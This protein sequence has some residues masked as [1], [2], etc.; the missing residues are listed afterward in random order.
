VQVSHVQDHVTHAVIGANAAQ[1]FSIAATAEFFN[2]LSNTLYSNK[3][4]AVV[5]E[6]LCNA[7]DAHI[8]AGR[9]DRAVEVTLT[10]DHLIIRDY[11]TGIKKALMHST[12]CIYGGSTKQHDGAQ[13]GGF[14]LG[15]KA[16]F[17]YV[18][19]F[20][21]TN[22]HDNQKTI[23][24]ISKSSGE[25][26]GLPGM[27]EI[28][29]IPTTETGMQVKIEI[30][31]GDYATF[32]ALVLRI[33]GAGEMN[34]RLNGATV[35]TL[36]LSQA[37]EGFLFTQDTTIL[38]SVQERIW[39]RYGNVLYP[40]NSH[41]EYYAPFAYATKIL[42]RMS[43]R[44]SY[45]A[46]PWRLVIQA[47]AHS[48]SVTPSRESLSMSERTI[49]TLKGLLKQVG[50]S[51]K[52]R[53][54][55]EQQQ[56]RREGIQKAVE[57]MRAAEMLEP[58]KKTFGF[59]KL[60]AQKTIDSVS[61][62][63]RIS[64][65]AN[66]P[67]D[68]GYYRKDINDRLHAIE[69]SGFGNRGLIQTYRRTWLKE[70][71]R[72]PRQDRTGWFQRRVVAPLVLAMKDQKDLDIDRMFVHG[73]SEHEDR[74]V[75]YDNT[76]F[77]TLRKFKKGSLDQYLPFLRNFV[78]LS[79]NRIDITERLYNQ[80]IMK[81]LGKREDFLFYVVQRSEPKVQAAREFFKNQGYLLI[82]LTV[83]HASEPPPLVDKTPREYKP[84]KKGI[85]KASTM[86]PKDYTCISTDLAKKEDAERIE[87]PEFIIKV[88]YRNN[89]T[90]F[91]PFSEE[92]SAAII[93]LFGDKAGVVINDTQAQKYIAGGAKPALEW[94]S[95]K[96]ITEL[97]NNAN[98]QAYMAVDIS[99]VTEDARYYEKWPKWLK[100]I[101]NDHFLATYYNIQVSLSQTEK[102]YLSLWKEIRVV[103]PITKEHVNAHAFLNKIPVRK[104]LLDLR[105]RIKNS[106]L[107]DVLS[108]LEMSAFLAGSNPSSQHQQQ[109]AKA[110][111]ILI[112][113]I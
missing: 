42:D 25:V 33:A 30:Q 74:Y 95:G 75:R 20:E 38:G 5:R 72:I 66:Y 67:T 17:A 12:Y 24:R 77:T 62:A 104:E 105:D 48:I 93:R 22:C 39:V 8:A 15:C 109:Q 45:G 3:P 59:E 86:L 23:Y 70:K 10:K 96:I 98:I 6:V 53:G 92:S 87:A 36:P 55:Q 44:N 13:T 49:E 82:D 97:R 7:W 101:A 81:W 1:S 103:S 57:A 40:V 110:R 14:G 73:Y 16:P 112:H 46:N 54:V 94:L 26:N 35:P 21:V 50:A 90:R 83:R 89:S 9:M 61:D 88:A 4:L 106:R 108:D 91:D 34:V 68:F 80:P 47:P 2:V 58:V 41:P 69:K 76:A 51:W 32:Y 29:D 63:A 11:G 102:D 56:A 31:P 78:V 111:D 27:M 52:S 64:L 107:I 113:A 84:R 71:D 37:K 28:L 65:Q 18:D 43:N 79:H 85:P 100:L 99:R 60:V 19:H